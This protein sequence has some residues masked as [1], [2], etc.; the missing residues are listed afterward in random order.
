MGRKHMDRYAFLFNL[1][2]EE[3]VKIRE[4]NKYYLNKIKS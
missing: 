3:I 1:S 2:V 4:N